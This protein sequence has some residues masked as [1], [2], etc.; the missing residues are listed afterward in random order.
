MASRADP[1]ALPPAPRLSGALRTALTDFYFNSGRLVPA[2][3]AWGLA[4][5]GIGFAL[6]AWP[7]VGLLLAPLLAVP[8]AG[9][10]RV[11][12]RVVRTEP[13]VSWRDAFAAWRDLGGP[14]LGLGAVAV[15]VAVIL[16]SNLVV[17][18]AQA[19]PVGWV[20]ATF[21][22]WGLVVLWCG[23]IAAWPILVDPARERQPVRQRLRLAALLVLA[24]PVRFAALGLAVGL[25]VVVSA[26]LTAVLLT[27]GVAYVALV[28]GRFVLPAADR[29]EARLADGR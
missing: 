20:M 26:L 23:A 19:D 13:D 9:V 4:A 11:A 16:G 7:L 29:L 1:V 24:F 25:V 6:L 3:A 2:N 12:A 28:A 5:L 14:A 27:V 18:L 17:G 15:A 10:F 22:G 8:T 21:A